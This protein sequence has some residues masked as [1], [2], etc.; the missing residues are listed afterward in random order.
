MNNKTNRFFTFAIGLFL[1]VG[2]ATAADK[3]MSEDILLDL[4]EKNQV[5]ELDQ[6][7]SLLPPA[8]TA[9]FTMKHG[10]M[11]DGPRGHKAEPDVPG[12][13]QH[14]EPLAPRTFLF[15]YNSGFVISYNGGKDSKGVAQQGGQTLDTMSF[16][17]TNKSFRLVKIDFPIAKGVKAQPN[18]KDCTSCH[19]PNNRPIFSMY[20]DWP[21]FYG[22][23]NDELTANTDIQKN[24][25]K[26]FTD[27]V[28]N[29]AE[30][31][32]RY[33][34]LFNAD[35]VKKYHGYDIYD[36]YPY[37]YNNSETPSELSRAFSFRAGLRFNL[38]YSRLL[39]QQVTKRII[40]HKQADKHFA[41]F[42]NFFVFNL[43]K[44]TPSSAVI[45]KWH[46]IVLKEL[47][48]VEANKSIEYF[49]WIPGT[50]L[51]SKGHFSLPNGELTLKEGNVLDYRQNLALFGLIVNDIDM[52]FSYYNEHYDDEIAETVMDVGYLDKKHFNSYNDG[53][54]TVDELL[55]ASLLGELRKT[56]KTLDKALTKQGAIALR[57]LLNKY[58]GP[59]FEE[60][61]KFDKPFYTQMDKLGKWFSLPYSDKVL[62]PHHR[63]P[64][65][66][67][68]KKN[69]K[70]I[71]GEL[72]KA[73]K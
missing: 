38:L 22:S 64:F 58:S 28:T 52:R 57:G 33:S 27:F 61:L 34:A 7:V 60:R 20:P 8:F 3:A 49:R 71:C 72:E 21:R 4:L 53:S 15:D 25:N 18:N 6:V 62:L 10:E 1:T 65:N 2:Q 45:K 69:H 68:Y 11:I 70:L 44:C 59:T 56:N 36:L 12:F 37:R 47:A 23:D 46:P 32:P 54:T 19:G 42:G 39:V 55:T 43:M 67:N 14:S 48:N 51:Q 35:T 30:K 40:E 9:H 24:E 73:L 13:G 50:G 31:H 66:D 17:A 16:D 63:A 26:H 5:T 41:T 29:V